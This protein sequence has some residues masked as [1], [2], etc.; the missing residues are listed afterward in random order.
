VVRDLVDGVMVVEE[1]QIMGAVRLLFERMK[2][3]VEPSG[4]A[5]LAAVLSEGFAAAISRSLLETSQPAKRL[6]VAVILSGGNVDLEA[7]GFW[8]EANWHPAAH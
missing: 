8:C 4:A 1:H 3:V 6:N 2:L 5:A 7:K